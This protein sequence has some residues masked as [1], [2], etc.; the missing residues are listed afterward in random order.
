MLFNKLRIGN[1]SYNHDCFYFYF[2]AARKFATETVANPTKLRLSFT[3]PHQVKKAEP[4]LFF[5]NNLHFL[6]FIPPLFRPF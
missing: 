5:D 4:E 1:Y 2:L 6:I 3:C